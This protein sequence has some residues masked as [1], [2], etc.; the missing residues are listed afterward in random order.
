MYIWKFFLHYNSFLSPPHPP[1]H[2]PSF[3]PPLHN[4]F[5]SPFAPTYKCWE[6]IILSKRKSIISVDHFWNIVVLR[7]GIK[8]EEKPQ[9]RLLPH[10][11]A[12]LLSYCFSE[13][14]DILQQFWYKWDLMNG[15]LTTRKN[16]I[17]VAMCKGFFCCDCYSLSP[18]PLGL[19]DGMTVK[20]LFINIK[21]VL[22]AIYMVTIQPWSLV[23]MQGYYMG[24]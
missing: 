7:N 10:L 19:L 17:M 14:Q 9:R 2:T 11:P 3:S 20:L 13:S 16:W 6:R 1:F 18:E 15:Y 8:R 21:L 22:N 23:M 4:F 24:L 5:P 12:F